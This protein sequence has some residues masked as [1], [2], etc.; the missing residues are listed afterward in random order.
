MKQLLKVY[1]KLEAA[2]EHNKAAQL[3]VDKFGTAEEQKI[4]RDLTKKVNRRG[5]LLAEEFKLRF[6]TAQKYYKQLHA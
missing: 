5:H 6:E 2:N 1:Q 4:I 3:L